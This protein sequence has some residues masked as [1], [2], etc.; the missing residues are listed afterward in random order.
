MNFQ[1][2]TI[3]HCHNVVI[4]PVAG[5][6]HYVHVRYVWFIPKVQP[7]AVTIEWFPAIPTSDRYAE[8]DRAGTLSYRHT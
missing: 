5:I 8:I 6:C 3:P 4:D 1:L 7:L 2:K